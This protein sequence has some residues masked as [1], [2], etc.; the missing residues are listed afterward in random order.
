MKK[1]IFNIFLLVFI[2]GILFSFVSC[3]GKDN[4]DN[5]P[6]QETVNKLQNDYGVVVEGTVFDSNTVVSF[7]RK[8]DGETKQIVASALANKEY[9]KNAEML[10]FDVSLLLDGKKIQP[11]SPV[12]VTVPTTNINLDESKEY[13]LFHIKDDNSVEL[14]DYTLN[15]NSIKFTTSSFSY[16]VIVEQEEEIEHIH[17]YGSMYYAVPATFF[18]DGNIAYY[19]C[20]ECGKYFDENKNEVKSVVIPKLSTDI[21]LLVNG[22]KAGEFSLTSSNDNLI[23]WDLIN[24]SL[25]KDDLIEVAD[26]N[27]ITKKYSFFPNT[28]SNIT[29]EFKVHNDV[30]NG[31]INIECTPNGL[32]LNIS[33]FKHEGLVLKVTRGEVVTEYPMV[34][35]SYD[36]GKPTESYIYGYLYVEVGD[37]AVIVDNDNDIT[38]DYLDVD[39]S[40]TWQTHLFEKGDNNEIIFKRETRV[41]FELFKDSKKIYID[42]VYA[43]RAVNE[44]SIEVKGYDE[45]MPMELRTLPINTDEYNE[46]AYVLLHESTLNT[47]DIVEAIANGVNVYYASTY[48]PAGTE[49]RISYGES[50]VSPYH[51]VDILNGGEKIELS[52]EY[53]KIKESGTY[54][55]EYLPCIDS[56]GVGLSSTSQYKYMYGGETFDIN[57]DENGIITLKDFVTK[58]FDTLTFLTAMSIIEVKLDS[59]VPA[60][61]ATSNNGVIMFYKAGI[62]DVVFD[63]NTNIVSITDKTPA[64]LIGG[65]IMNLGS[66]SSKTFVANP[67]NSAEAYAVGVSVTDITQRYAITDS[68]SGSVNDI[69]IDPASADLVAV[70]YPGYNFITFKETGTYTIYI[71]LTTH[72]IRVEKT[73]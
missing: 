6:K 51:V 63:T 37:I 47:D 7:E 8:S 33:G 22:T 34:E 55:I 23:V 45:K 4:N 61:V 30:T 41:G 71:N 15:N 53:F 27:D 60:T 65:M 24:I 14:L 12:S 5:T 20:E 64:S 50:Y 40:K 44:C 38:Y 48:L 54:M 16:F 19:L 72:V 13:L 43:P 31:V 46:M 36:F 26:K 73:N 56:Y 28:S 25:K 62:Y 52:D 58:D 57:P 21:V 17:E 11:D 42:A 2:F 18:A 32:Y 35:I 49:I 67:N 70:F 68:K 29:D 66:Y 69:S 9:N 3:S 59:S 1:K 10:I 39:Q